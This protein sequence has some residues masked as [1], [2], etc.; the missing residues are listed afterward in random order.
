MEYS[1]VL[2]LFPC[3][4]VFLGQ[5]GEPTV[6]CG[7]LMSL[8]PPLLAGR[9]KYSSLVPFFL[10]LFVANRQKLSHYYLSLQHVCQVEQLDQSCRSFEHKDVGEPYQLG[11]IEPPRERGHLNE[12]TSG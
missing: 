7:S 11:H 1:T 3:T 5:D 6:D 9:R 12:P 4:D 10:H 8:N 2:P